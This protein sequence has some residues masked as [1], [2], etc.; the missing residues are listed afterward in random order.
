MW[1]LRRVFF[2]VQG[3]DN[4]KC[5]ANAFRALQVYT[6]AHQLDESPDNRE[7]QTSSRF[8]SGGDTIPVAEWFKDHFLFLSR[9]P[10]TGI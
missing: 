4:R 10:R 1:L 9:D 8:F 3:K 7:S 6:T 2:S 5:A